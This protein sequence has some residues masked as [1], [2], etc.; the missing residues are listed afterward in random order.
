MKYPN[1]LR[2]ATRAL[3]VDLV[4][5]LQYL[6]KD[7]LSEDAIIALAT[8]AKQ[9][10]HSRETFSAWCLGLEQKTI[11]PKQLPIDGDPF[12]PNIVPVPDSRFGLVYDLIN[13]FLI[14]EP[15]QFWTPKIEAAYS[16][17]DVR[18]T[19]QPE[20]APVEQVPLTSN[21]LTPEESTELFG[22]PPTKQLI[23][24]GERPTIKW[25]EEQGKAI[26]NVLKWY[27]KKDKSRPIYRL[28]GWAG[29]GKTSIIQEISFAIRAGEGVPVGEV[30][31]AAFTGKAAAVMMSKGCSPASTIHSLIY[32]PKIDPVTGKVIGFGIN[33]ES[34][35]RYASLLICDEVS[36]VNEELAR[37]LLSFDVPILVVGDPG[38]LDPIR[39]EGYFVNEEADSL[40]T[41][42]ER[43]AQENPLIWLATK[44]RN[45][46]QVK[47]GTYGSTRIYRGKS[48]PDELIIEADQ[49]LCG[50]NRTRQAL[51]R[52]YRVLA[53]FHEQ[54]SQFPV[55]GDRLM[56]LKNNKDTGVLNGTQW[57][58]SEPI[59]KPVRRLKDW[60]N[61]GL[62]MEDTN[63]EGLHFRARACDL[64]DSNGDPLII[65]TVC[66]AHHFDENLPEPPWKDIAGT[67]EY[68]F[69]YASTVHRYQGSQAPHIVIVDESFV[70]REQEWKHRYTAFTRAS[71]RADI[72]L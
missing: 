19:P 66:S 72:F 57:H 31:F 18:D 58:C 14:E 16:L 9:Q 38:Q 20:A 49:L 15:D 43:V 69:A 55:R 60:R 35:L 48:V 61:P 11:M 6:E 7:R 23:R 10:P 52:R 53:G 30:M 24:T 51:N 13:S 25:N 41:R 27:K 36:M 12:S 33:D 54:D 56:G 1:K 68:T 21:L 59:I 28:F 44:V 63:I 29:T 8:W 62:G 32:R 50:M 26:K 46:E 34:P 39:G 42:V 65:N 67:D 45:G 3:V 70:F 37:D 17:P 71:E 2:N 22:C 47:P 64:F 4:D 5:R 40:L